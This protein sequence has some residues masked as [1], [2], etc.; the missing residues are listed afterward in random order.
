MKLSLENQNS[1]ASVIKVV[2]SKRFLIKIL[3]KI[4]KYRYVQTEILYTDDILVICRNASCSSV[5]CK[6]ICM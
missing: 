6:Y 5:A 4:F 1:E 3:Y 2:L